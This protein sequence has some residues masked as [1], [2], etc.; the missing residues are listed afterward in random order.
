[1]TWQ[2]LSSSLTKKDGSLRNEV[3]FW[4][5]AILL[6]LFTLTLSTTS[7]ALKQVFQYGGIL[8]CP[9]YFLSHLWTDSTCP[10]W[11]SINLFFP[12]IISP[13]YFSQWE[14]RLFLI[15]GI[16]FYSSFFSCCISGSLT[17]LTSPENY[18]A[19]SYNNTQIEASEMV[20]LENSY[21]NNSIYIWKHPFTFS[22]LFE[23]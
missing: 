18:T 20:V 4:K 8:N 12:P 7:T 19:N 17:K 10:T 6:T 16:D 1:M 23:S 21:W 14:C 3:F 15:P 9:F 11:L 5:S 13:D 22:M 2:E